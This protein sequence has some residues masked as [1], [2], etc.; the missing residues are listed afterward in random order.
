MTGSKFLKT[1]TVS[2]VL[3]QDQIA[4]DPVQKV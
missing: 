1:L 3:E 2:G 4:V